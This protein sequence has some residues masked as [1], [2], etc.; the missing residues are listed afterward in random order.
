MSGE[1]DI[2]LAEKRVYGAARDETVAFVGS[3]MGLARVTVSGDQVGRFGLV[4][5]RTV[6]DVAGADGKL[7]VATDED[8]LIGTRGGEDIAFEGTK[9]GPATAVGLADGTP[10]AA[11]PDGRV[12]TLAGDRWETVDVLEGVHAIDGPYLATEDGVVVL[13][14][15]GI[16][17]LGL[18]G[19]RDV[20]ARGPHAA[21][22]EGLFQ[23]G[24]GWETA[25][26]GAFSLVGA[27]PA[28]AHAVETEDDQLWVR[29]DG[30]WTEANPPTDESV[31][32]VAYGE[33]P[34]LVT[35]DGTFLVDANA[36]VTPDG[37]AGWGTRALGIRDVVGVA[38]P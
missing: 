1:Q 10:V 21:A 8:V 28:G 26:I 6:T 5:R 35:A 22:A 29:R 16:E 11:G 18:G 2:S 20:A 12:A 7:L 32:G 38:V 9:F 31:V 25:L 30:E 17:N 36:A 27:S 24:E 14:E 15:G 23:A 19:V 3:N 13:T 4:D 37:A 33:C 34:Y